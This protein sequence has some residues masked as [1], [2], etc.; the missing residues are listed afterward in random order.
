MDNSAEQQ[1]NY[2][3]YNRNVDTTIHVRTNWIEQLRKEYAKNNAHKIITK[4]K[5]DKLTF[6]QW[7]RLCK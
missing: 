3:K 4:V 7:I 5:I 6:I 1:E 2:Y